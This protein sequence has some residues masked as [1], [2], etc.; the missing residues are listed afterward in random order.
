MKPVFAVGRT[1]NDLKHRGYTI[2][3]TR[4]EQ[5]LALISPPGSR[6]VMTK[7]GTATIQ[8]G[9]ARALQRAKSLIDAIESSK[10]RPPPDDVA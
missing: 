9:E 7:Q 3:T 8:E 1:M 2:R 6:Q 10:V 4:T 5:W